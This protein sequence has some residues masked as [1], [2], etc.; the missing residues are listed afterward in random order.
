M[1]TLCQWGLNALKILGRQFMHEVFLQKKRLQKDVTVSENNFYS[2]IFNQLWAI[3]C[4]CMSV[5]R[6]WLRKLLSTVCVPHFIWWTQYQSDGESGWWFTPLMRHD[7]NR[8]DG[9]GRHAALD[10]LRNLKL[11]QPL[12]WRLFSPLDLTVFT[13][14]PTLKPNQFFLISLQQLVKLKVKIHLHHCSC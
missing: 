7:E 9:S 5:C 13:Q 14:R 6:G 11:S 3:V 8:R 10:R 1:C 4:V 12:R 2:I